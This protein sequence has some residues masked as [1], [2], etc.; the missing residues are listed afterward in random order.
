MAD[1]RMK[2]SPPPP[3]VSP[4]VT[5]RYLSSSQVFKNTELLVRLA[6]SLLTR[7][8]LAAAR[9]PRLLPR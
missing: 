9:L 2:D 6:S 5:C 1:R 4:V 8:F 3:L 7:L